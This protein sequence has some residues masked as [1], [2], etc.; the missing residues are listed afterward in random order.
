[1]QEAICNRCGASVVLSARFC[2]QC[3]NLLDPSE[4]TTRS[5]DAPPAEPPPYDH[6]TRPANAGITAPTYAPPQ[7]YMQPPPPAPIIGNAPSSSNKTAL[8]IFLA[9][10]L[11]VLIALG[12][13]AFVLLG[14][15]SGRQLTPP[16]PPPPVTEKAPPPPDNHGIIPHPPQPPPPPG[17][18]GPGQ[19]K[20]SL[21]P[22]F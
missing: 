18:P 2:R 19:V 17:N 13:A 5:L 9:L 6:P 14:R 1:M 10:G 11:T 16:P 12:V 15:F 20:T 22:S 3:G 4:M 21:D 8:V 7:A